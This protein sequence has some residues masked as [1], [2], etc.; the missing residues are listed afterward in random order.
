MDLVTA[1]VLKQIELKK[2]ICEIDLP[3]LVKQD[4]IYVSRSLA[5]L[6]QSELIFPVGRKYD[7]KYRKIFS[8]YTTDQSKVSHYKQQIEQAE[9]REQRVRFVKIHLLQIVADKESYCSPYREMHRLLINGTA[10]IKDAYF[11]M[12]RDELARLY[13]LLAD[14]GY[15]TMQKYLGVLGMS[16]QKLKQHALKKATAEILNIYD[17]ERAQQKL[18]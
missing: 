13:L 8:V 17:N 14:R 10:Q 4:Y 3:V 18:F 11:S 5:E 16:P 12:N 2:Y 9:Y 6:Q 1:A 15:I 7:E